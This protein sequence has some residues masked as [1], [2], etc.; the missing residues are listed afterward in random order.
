[1]VDLA[2]YRIYWGTTP[3]NYTNSATLDNP[4]VST[5][6]VDGLAPGT[7][8]FAATSFNAAGIESTFSNPATMTVP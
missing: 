2:G 7:Y 6:T 5:Y 4:G 1:L 3:G 8:E